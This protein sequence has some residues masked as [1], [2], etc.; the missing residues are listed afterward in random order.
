MKIYDVS[1]PI[2]ATL[3]IYEGDPPTQ[4]EAVARTAHGD[5][6]NVSRITI[7]SHT[8]THVDPPS[9]FLDGAPSVD[10]LPLEVLIGPALVIDLTQASGISAAELDAAG[11]PA[12]TERL[13]LKTRNS[14]LWQ[15]GGFRKDFLGLREEA[16]RRLVEWGVR[17]VGIDYLS[18]APYD[19]P[20]AA[21]LPLL[22]AGVVILEGLDL[23]AIRPGRYTL[24]CLPLKIQG[25]DGAPA[26][27]V[28]I[29]EEDG[30]R[31]A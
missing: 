28:L 14:Q 8:G 2:T 23:S 19:N 21:H 10:A 11:V 9:H 31:S 29:E 18:I 26:R 22:Q 5:L 25:G 7:G 3:P 15:T 20:R 30:R 1:V 13:L 12:G 17:L 24:V 4:I 16:A 27:A 6:A